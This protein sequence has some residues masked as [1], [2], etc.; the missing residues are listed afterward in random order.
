MHVEQHD[1]VNGLGW[2][3]YINQH[4]MVNGLGWIDYINA[5]SQSCF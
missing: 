5:D 3:D 4:D 1:M 2:I